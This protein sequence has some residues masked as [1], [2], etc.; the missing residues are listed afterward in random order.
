MTPNT[1][2]DVSIASTVPLSREE[3]GERLGDSDWLSR[4]RSFDPG[5]IDG[6]WRDDYLPMVVEPFQEL[7]EEA[8]RLGVNVTKCATL[9]T[10]GELTERSR[11][12][13]LFT[14]W[15]GS[16]IVFDDLISP[17]PLRELMERAATDNGDLAKYI[18]TRLRTRR[19]IKSQSPWR[20]M[21]SWLSTAL[22]GEREESPSAT[23]LEVLNDALLAPLPI[24][25]VGADGLQILE[26]EVSREARRRDEM[27][28]LFAGLLRPGNR[29]EL[30]DGM[31][32]KRRVEETIAPAFDGVLDLGKLHLHRACG[33][34]GASEKEPYSDGPVSD[35][36]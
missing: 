15:K 29:L 20:R 17:D 31:Q 26:S 2:A 5:Q 36:Y 19:G 12:V 28:E 1:P 7:S 33:L 35:A 30:F 18:L 9:S 3:F 14:H 8:A 23:V 25:T 13:V 6:F 10:L 16:A 21:G 27:D 4:Y 32:P 34:S 11:I 22:G 24:E